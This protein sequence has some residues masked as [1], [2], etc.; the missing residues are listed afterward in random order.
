MFKL[1]QSLSCEENPSA[2][3]CL[4]QRVRLGLC[5][6]LGP[7]GPPSSLLPVPL[8]GHAYF[9]LGD[10][11]S[12]VS[13]SRIFFSPIFPWLVP[14]RLLGLSLNCTLQ[15]IPSIA[16]LDYYN[17]PPAALHASQSPTPTPPPC[18]ADLSP[19]GS[20]LQVWPPPGR[21]ALSSLDS[22]PHT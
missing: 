6:P 4:V 12:L 2:S 11:I 8:T 13:L 1:L 22:L 5:P 21:P 16:G 7:H 20:A 14:S 17:H 9:L 15:R 3:S 19:V 18:L 10:F